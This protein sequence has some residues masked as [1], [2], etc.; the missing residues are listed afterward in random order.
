MSSP[1]VK[2][3][4][5]EEYLEIEE[6]NEFRSEFAH[7]EMF[8]MAETT[9]NHSWVVSNVQGELWQ[10][11][12]GRPCGVRTN[13]RRLYITKFEAFTYPDVVVTCGPDR[14]YKDGR[15]LSD[16]TV[17]IEVLS[18]S[19]RN[20]DRSEKFDFYRSLPS[21]AEYLLLA[22]DS[23]RAEHCTRLPDG[24]WH[25]REFT[26]ATDILELKSIG[27]RLELQ[28]LYERVEFA[29]DSQTAG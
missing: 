2:Y 16:A 15:T 26:A 13:E 28:T 11:L 4:T 23:R 8:A 5:P 19:T 12:R 9:N 25:F 29:A 17:I 21:F 22:Q 27:C 10:Q 24:S 14:L 1:P 3:L 18:P 7:G 6:K 20:Y